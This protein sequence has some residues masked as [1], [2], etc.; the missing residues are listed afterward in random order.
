M[1]EITVSWDRIQMAALLILPSEVIEIIWGF[2]LLRVCAC[3]L[4]VDGCLPCLCCD[5]ACCTLA[6]CQSLHTALRHFFSRLQTV[7]CL[8]VAC[9]HE[10]MLL[11]DWLSNGDIPEE[12][13][14]VMFPLYCFVVN[15]K[16]CIPALSCYFQSSPERELHQS[17]HY[18]SNTQNVFSLDFF[19]SLSVPVVA[20]PQVV[21]LQSWDQNGFLWQSSSREGSYI[22]PVCERGSYRHWASRQCLETCWSEQAKKLRQPFNCGAYG[23]RVSLFP[24]CKCSVFVQPLAEFSFFGSQCFTLYQLIQVGI[25]LR[26]PRKNSSAV[27]TRAVKN[28]CVLNKLS[29][30]SLQEF[31]LLNSTSLFSICWLQEV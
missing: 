31:Q 26:N 8:L 12:W 29:V 22:Q 19:L 10:S 27:I 9:Y 5:R 11:A 3:W 15:K 25:G 24:E 18:M 13:E 16:F 1:G 17:C 4:C 14:V 21:A 2:W 23:V 7:P 6:H 20:V 30:S 28:C